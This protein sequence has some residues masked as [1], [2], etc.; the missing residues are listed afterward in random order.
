[1]KAQFGN[2]KWNRGFRLYVKGS[3][4]VR[5]RI[6]VAFAAHNVGKIVKARK[7]GLLV[8]GSL[9]LLGWIL[10]SFVCVAVNMNEF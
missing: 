6:L 10:S 9:F 7:A 4:K 1:M 8:S 2:V 3:E 5:V